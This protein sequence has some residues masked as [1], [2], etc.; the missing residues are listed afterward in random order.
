MNRTIF[1][2]EAHFSL[3]MVPMGHLVTGADMAAADMGDMVHHH[4]ANSTAHRHMEGW[5]N[6]KI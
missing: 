4:M 2:F 5:K 1:L 3:V 6:K